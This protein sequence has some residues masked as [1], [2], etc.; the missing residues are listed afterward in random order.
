MAE[1]ELTVGEV[2]APRE[3]DTE[4]GVDPFLTEYNAV[5]Q[6]T[7]GS[8]TATDSTRPESKE[9]GEVDGLK[10]ATEVGQPQTTAK[11]SAP[12]LNKLS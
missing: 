10:G 1:S 4:Q 12:H 8:D 6:E 3:D 5:F 2:L 11:N 9:T 7:M